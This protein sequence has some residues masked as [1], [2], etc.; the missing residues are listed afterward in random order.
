[1]K[2]ICIKSLLWIITLIFP[3]FTFAQVQSIAEYGN[4]TIEELKQQKYE[5]DTTT[6]AV[7]LHQSCYVYFNYI[8]NI[9]YTIEEEFFV[10]KK[11]LKPSA[12]NLGI[13]KIP[14]FKENY[15]NAQTLND[16]RG[17]TYWI[18]D[19]EISKKELI[20]NDIFEEKM[21]SN[22]F[23]NKITFPNITE[24]CIIEY[25]YR[26]STPIKVKL[27]P[28]KWYFQNEKPILWSQYD[29]T[30]P[31]YYDYKMII[32]GDLPV[33][34]KPA[35]S[36]FITFKN[37]VLNTQGMHY[38][39][40]VTNAPAFKKEP[41]ISSSED[42]ISKIDF[43][44]LNTTSGNLF[45]EK[46]LNY[47][48][49][50]DKL[51]KI[52]N[53]KENFGSQLKKNKYSKDIAKRFEE[54]SN[55]LERLKKAYY[56]MQ[57]EIAT[58]KSPL[59]IYSDDVKTIFENKIGTHSEQN[60]LFVNVLRTMGYNANPVILSTREN[61]KIIQDYALLDR[62]NYTICRVELNNEIFNLDVSDKSLKMGM[63][64][65]ECLN[66]TGREI[67]KNEG[68]FVDL[69][70]KE[71]F[72][73]Y[74]VVE[75]SID[76]N[77][78]KYIGKF[79]ENNLGYLAY[80]KRKEL[81]SMGEKDFTKS[82]HQLFFDFSLKNLKLKNLDNPEEL[83]II[84]FE[85]ES[86]DDIL[87]EDIFYFNPMIGG[88]ITENPFKQPDR[89]Y[90]LDLGYATDLTY[91]LVL[92]IPKEIEIISI[93]KSLN[94]SVAENNGI[95]LFSCL[96]NDQTNQID[97]VSKIT[98]KKPKYNVAEYFELKELFNQIV[99]KHQEQIVFRK[100]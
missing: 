3:K 68:Q 18:E 20:P 22:Q 41:F 38:S 17:T 52:L 46:S 90:Y 65:F 40:S 7:I 99:Q 92:N 48:T 61:G 84:Q 33:V 14:I 93:P 29:I 100:K 54:I 44:L 15:L 35:I 77:K 39:F 81:K 28:T 34:Q 87:D 42:Y 94:V 9:G 13:L 25:S 72:K 24:G 74:E 31:F 89:M 56:F 67:K 64:P 86:K 43:E 11:I 95:F 79:E 98:L 4:V 27:K 12:F 19:N 37:R 8:E 85:F 51:D 66:E 23:E 57:K 53:V 78:K 5:I 21:S 55:P 16:F 60:L 6:D 45:Y 36:E 80:N 1:M 76:L 2:Q 97:L 59:Q 49:D 58:K 83:Q 47:L 26:I 82:Y 70:P 71:K 69:T 62:F 30:I 10:R 96:Y 73:K 75:A 50:W 63:L 91:K 32:G 88:K